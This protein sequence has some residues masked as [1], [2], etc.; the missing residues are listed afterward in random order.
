MLF[1]VKDTGIGIPKSMLDNI[2]MPYQQVDN[3]ITTAEGSGLGLSISKKLLQLMNATLKVDS[4]LGEGS[5]FSF[6]LTLPVVTLS[7]LTITELAYQPLTVNKKV[8]TDA[9]DKKTN[10][11]KTDN[12]ISQSNTKLIK[13]K[14]PETAILLELNEH[15][16]KHNILALKKLITELDKQP[17]LCHFTQ[18]IKPYVQKYQFS[19]LLDFLHNL[20]E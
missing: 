19:Q 8:L 14:L 7:E 20:S 5:C 10:L 17:E 3:N 15:T 12:T 2:F 18:Q 11:R 16:E 4:Q 6:E 1:T 9:Q 13:L